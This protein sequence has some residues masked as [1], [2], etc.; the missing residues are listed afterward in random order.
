MID[1]NADIQASIERILEST[2]DEFLADGNL[3]DRRFVLDRL[4][5]AAQ[6]GSA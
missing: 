1:P 3:E 2:C 5:A 6:E 4:V